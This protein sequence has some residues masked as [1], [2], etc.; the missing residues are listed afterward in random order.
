M[1]SDIADLRGADTLQC[2]SFTL[3]IQMRVFGRWMTLSTGIIPTI[4]QSP[5][6]IFFP[7]ELL[8]LFNLVTGVELLSLFCLVTGVGN[9]CHRNTWAGQGWPAQSPGRAVSGLRKREACAARCPAW[10]AATPQWC[11]TGCKRNSS[12]EETRSASVAR[13]GL[14][15]NLRLQ[16]VVPTISLQGRASKIRTWEK[17]RHMHLSI[18]SW[19]TLHGFAFLGEAGLW[20]SPGG[21][22]GKES[23]CQCWRCKRCLHPWVGKIPWR[24]KRQPTPVFLPGKVHG[25]RSLAGYSSWSLEELDMWM[26][27]RGFQGDR[28]GPAQGSPSKEAEKQP[29]S[30]SMCQQGGLG[31]GAPAVLR[32]CMWLGVWIYWNSS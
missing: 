16:L 30:G 31:G 32:L 8:S 5:R 4:H 24:R 9:S 25:L 7:L 3:L 6:R 1:C 15:P 14:R 18:S 2:V 17:T 28:Q 12:R 21:K 26:H 19:Q 23:A 27:T 20:S 10:L 13:A 29:G 11:S 22:S